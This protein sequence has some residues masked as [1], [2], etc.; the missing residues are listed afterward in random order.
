MRSTSKPYKLEAIWP[1][2]DPKSC[3]M[4]S[5]IRHFL[6][7]FSTGFAEILFENAKLMLNNVPQVLCRC[8][9]S[10]L[11]YRESSLGG[12]RPQA[13]CGLRAKSFFFLTRQTVRRIAKTRPPIDTYDRPRVLGTIKFRA[14][15][16]MNFK[17]LLLWPENIDSDSNSDY[18]STPA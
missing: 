3:G 18:G 5:L 1:F 4:T 15:E 6:Q 8:L 7:N 2:F 11:R 16:S 9:F 14:A 17:R 10:F 12:I 13:N